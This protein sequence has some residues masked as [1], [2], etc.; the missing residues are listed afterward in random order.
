MSK[1]KVTV[2]TA[3]K[4]LTM[5]PGRPEAEAVAVLDG[6]V[7]ST[8]TMDFMEPWLERYEVTVDDTF[9]DKVILPG[10]MEPHSH[11][12][13]SA[14]FLALTYV[15]PLAWP[16]PSGM[17]TP[18]PTGADMM[19]TLKKLHEEEKD[20]N[21]P[22]IAWGYDRA[23]QDDVEPN[24]DELNKITSERPIWIISW[25]PHFYY[26]NDA[27]LKAA[28]VA[29]DLVHPHAL[30]FPDG[31]LSGVFTEPEGFALSCGP[32]MGEI[33]KFSTVDG[34]NYFAGL[35]N[36]AGVTTVADLL[37]G[38]INWDAELA[39]HQKATADPE[40]PIRMRLTPHGPLL[41]TTHG[42][43]EKAIEFL[44][45]LRSKVETDK[46][47]FRGLKFLSDGSYPLLGAKMGF[48]GYLDG[49]DG[50]PGDTDQANFMRPYWEAG[51]HLHCHANGDA[52]LEATLD[53][54]AQLQEWHPRF[55]HRFTVEHFSVSTPMQCR[56][57]KALGG[58]ASVNNYF[59]HFRALLHTTHGY[60]PDRA[61]STARLRTLESEGVV[62]GLHSDYPQVVVPMLP[63][64][65]VY[66]AVNRIAE[67]GKTVVAPDERIGV[68]RALRAVTIDAAYVLGLE[69]KVGSL[70]Q[71]KF[72]DFCILEE[73]PLEVEPEHIKDI[74]IWGTVLGGKK[75]KCKEQK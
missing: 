64:T 36:H 41:T 22:I 19:A 32:A 45:D 27:A 16:T 53:N 10:M 44:R 3:R 66:A 29:E 72:A 59:S 69:D 13:M 74:K 9:K 55:D 62:F 47:F 50:I 37:F 68:E 63:L 30:K 75:F 28:G 57:L 51:E 40:F 73:D 4:V 52:A 35:A 49:S 65:A 70:E 25:A 43:G 21:K 60:G 26:L 2:F 42:S 17:S 46:L 15:G 31:R 20:P 38:S 7:L 11:C 61:Q 56:R 39:D 24:R 58:V 1:E 18:N 5:D 8:G 34:L 54:L 23:T 33:A 12:W 71:G 48:P 67:D 6:K 14:G